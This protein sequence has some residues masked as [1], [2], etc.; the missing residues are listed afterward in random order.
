MK[1]RALKALDDR[2]AIALGQIVVVF[3]H[4]GQPVERDTAVQMVDVVDADVCAR[5]L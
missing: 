4:F 5:P 2:H 1:P 3:E